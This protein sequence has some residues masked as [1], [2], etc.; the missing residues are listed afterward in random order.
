MLCTSQIS[1]LRVSS[2]FQYQHPFE[3]VV[4]QK[5]KTKQKMKRRRSIY[6]L[7][8]LCRIFCVGTYS[9]IE[10]EGWPVGRRLLLCWM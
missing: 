2:S 6:Y 1:V 9:L 8:L 4:A 7:Y 3:S 5:S 10:C